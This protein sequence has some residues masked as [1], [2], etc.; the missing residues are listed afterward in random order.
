MILGVKCL[1]PLSRVSTFSSP[2]S[3]V[4]HD[5]GMWRPLLRLRSDSPLYTRSF[6][7]RSHRSV[8][9]LY[10]PGLHP[11]PNLTR[12]VVPPS[13]R[14]RLPRWSFH[15]S[16]FRPFFTSTVRKPD[17]TGVTPTTKTKSDFTFQRF[18]KSRLLII[19][20]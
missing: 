4:R 6:S 20:G 18:I 19:L 7:P 14:P 1:P 2:L 5:P 17:T 9:S 11:G 15:H 8:S 13:H 10:L 12:I 16:P 3:I